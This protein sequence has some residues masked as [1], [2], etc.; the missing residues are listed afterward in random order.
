M[1]V[2][3]EKAYAKLNLSL[4]V[5]ARREDGYHELAMLMQTVSV[6]DELTLS[7]NDTGAVSASCSLHFIPTDER[8]LA[9]RAAHAYLAAVGEERGVHIRMEKRI[10][11]GA[12]MGGGS[13]DAA[14]VLR[15]MNRLFDERLSRRELEG[16]ACS[17]GSDVA[18]CV[19]GGSALARGRGE[20]LEDLPA[21]PACI[22]V[23]A[24]PDFSI[25]TPELYRKLDSVA[26]RR[27]PD[28]A[29]LLEAV[30]QGNLREICRRMYNVFED[31]P[32]RRMRTVN[33][34]K[35][36][37]LDHGALGAM[38]TGTGSAVF[39]VFDDKTGAEAARETLEKEF[40]FCTLA[41]PVARYMD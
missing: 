13:A 35:G 27:H 17:I 26:L 38:M 14:A 2:Q 9:V 37:L 28:T 24:K 23:I 6:C 15:G 32:D 40:R 12:G 5:T 30:G 39:G 19:A 41:E 36:V 16:L 4:D 1:R 3:Q 31:V 33:E 11:V 21:L 29:G 34:I 10:P 18:F 8:N 7:L 25:S 22:F 20:L